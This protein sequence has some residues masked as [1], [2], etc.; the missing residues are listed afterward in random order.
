M[1]GC[2]DDVYGPFDENREDRSELAL[3]I[4]KTMALRQRRPNS[5]ASVREL[6]VDDR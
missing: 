1:T 4:G 5:S 2:V 6:P 3:V